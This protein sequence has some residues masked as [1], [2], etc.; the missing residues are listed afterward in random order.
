MEVS[1]FYQHSLL[2]ETLFIE[3]CIPFAEREIGDMGE[4]VR[5]FSSGTALGFHLCGGLL[6]IV[7]SF[8]GIYY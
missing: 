5:V 8:I 7:V 6:G 1:S 3:I 4:L 2:Q